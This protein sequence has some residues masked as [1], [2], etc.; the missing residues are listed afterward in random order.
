M[1]R[2]A[3]AVICAVA[4]AAVLAACSSSTPAGSTVPTATTAAATPRPAPVPPPNGKPVLKL[5]GLLSNRNTGASLTF[6]QKTLGA[7]ST[8]S[9]T[10]QEPFVKRDIRF[11]GIPMS[12]QRRGPGSP[13]GSGSSPRSLACSSSPCR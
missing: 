3:G 12:S 6:D 8:E 5:V 13:G 1:Q 2:T 4:L 10:V 11:T 9:A 7:M